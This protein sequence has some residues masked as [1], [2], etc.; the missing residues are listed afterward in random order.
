MEKY[1]IILLVIA[2]VFF[3]IY[4]Y[5]RT[6]S[7]TCMRC[8][9]ITNSFHSHTYNKAHICDECFKLQTANINASNTNNTYSAENT[10]NTSSTSNNSH[11]IY[12]KNISNSDNTFT[13]SIN[14]N[15]IFTDGDFT[16]FNNEFNPF[17]KIN[18]FNTDTNTEP[19]QSTYEIDNFI[20]I[21]ENDKTWSLYPFNEV[22]K[23]SDLIDYSIKEGTTN[24]SIPSF[25][26]DK[27]T[28][29]KLQTNN[30]PF[31]FDNFFINAANTAPLKQIELTV[32]LKNSRQFTVSF[33]SNNQ[34][35]DS[36]S[37]DD[38]EEITSLLEKI[39]N[40]A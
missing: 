39:K 6:R 37:N 2:A 20:A 10:S 9:R 1:I 24:I 3:I 12:T 36:S 26:M 34:N 17:S 28:I 30:I 27:D 4:F 11:T 38:V 32:V 21:N 19:F 18:P 14:K 29:D 13:I 5:K 23:Y 22:F 8:G 31:D 35:N 7:I 25:N 15:D 40:N 16:K 33:A